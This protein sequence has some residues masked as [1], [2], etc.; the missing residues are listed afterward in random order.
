MHDYFDPDIGDTWEGG[1]YGHAPVYDQRTEVDSIDYLT[2]E[3]TEKAVGFIEANK[4]SPFFLHMAY[5][6]VHGP[7]QAPEEYLE[8]YQDEEG[9]YGKIRA[10][11]KA[12][13]DC[14]GK[15]MECL[16]KL[17]L[18]RKT[19]VFYI[20]DNGGTG[21]HHNWVLKGTKGKVTEGGIRVPFM[22][23]YPGVIPEN[24]VYHKP[25]ISLDIMPIMLALAGIPLPGDK[26]LDGVNLIPFLTGEN[27]G[28]P[29][30]VLHWCWDPNFFDRWAIRK[31]RWKALREE[32]D[33]GIIYGLYDLEVD[34]SERNN[35]IEEFPEIFNELEKQHHEWAEALPPSIV[36]P[37]EWTPNGNGWT[38]VYD[39]ET[40]E[41]R[42][43]H[44]K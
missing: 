18:D 33:D 44:H 10:M 24:L 13:D 36:G 37:D 1:A 35:L 28:D 23:R 11:N 17:G 26:M 7:F 25:V 12:L 16:D 34:P 21:A 40:G 29:H 20:N 42:E 30:D 6:A 5:N 2:F 39:Q 43:E 9:T 14:I 38:Y 8:M 19:V 27:L 32:M 4:D 41:V 22:I 31:G 3:F 15:I